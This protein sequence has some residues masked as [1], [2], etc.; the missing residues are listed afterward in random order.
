MTL[1]EQEAPP[2]S[3]ESHDPWFENLSQRFGR[4]EL[5]S[6]IKVAT[7]FH[8]FR[9][10]EDA[11]AEVRVKRGFGKLH[12]IHRLSLILSPEEIAHAQ[13]TTQD[14]NHDDQKI[15]DLVSGENGV[16][17]TLDLK[18][19]THRLPLGFKMLLSPTEDV[20]STIVS[21]SFNAALLTDHDN[22]HS[23][24]LFEPEEVLSISVPDNNLEAFEADYSSMIMLHE[25]PKFVELLELH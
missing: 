12:N 24:E 6:L 23:G 3:S 22:P 13:Q 17:V 19:V 2:R 16:L 25:N 7:I 8:G 5:Q 20:S 11:Q 10:I 4:Q 18:G 9:D 14:F 15:F 1:V 21:S